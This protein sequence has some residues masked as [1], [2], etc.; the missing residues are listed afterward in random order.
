[1]N[2]NPAPLAM[3][4]SNVAYFGLRTGR[5]CARCGVIRHN[6][7]VCEAGPLNKVCRHKKS[8]PIELAYSGPMTI[9]GPR[10]E[11]LRNLIERNGE[12]RVKI[13]KNDPT[14]ADRA[15]F[16]TI[17]AVYMGPMYSKLDND[18]P[19]ALEQRKAARRRLKGKRKK[20]SRIPQ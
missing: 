16:P 14:A 19:A 9:L 17:I 13:E 10:P 3:R 18:P 6:G 5:K 11:V 20:L 12:T 7:D 2:A 1:M 4:Q 8:D 15:W